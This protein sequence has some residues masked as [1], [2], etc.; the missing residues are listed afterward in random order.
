MKFKFYVRFKSNDESEI[1]E[2]EKYLEE[3]SVQF[4]HLS[5]DFG[6]KGGT[7]LYSIVMDSEQE[8]ALR[9]SFPLVGCINFQKVIANL[10]K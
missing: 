5:R 8:L 2:F 1:T 3:R 10:K 6:P 9:L 7:N 4:E